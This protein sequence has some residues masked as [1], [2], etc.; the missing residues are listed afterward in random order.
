MGSDLWVAL[1][2]TLQEF[3][4]T[5]TRSLYVCPKVSNGSKCAARKKDEPLL[6][7][8]NYGIVEA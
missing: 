8:Q 4:K 7:K 1:R 2:D 3:R 5:T 6:I